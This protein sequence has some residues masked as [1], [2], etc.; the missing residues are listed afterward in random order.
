MTL[1]QLASYDHP[2]YGTGYGEET[3]ENFE[4]FFEQNKSYDV[5]LNLCYR[6]DLRKNDDGT[7]NLEL[8]TILQRKGKVVS[9]YVDKFEQKDVPLLQ[10]YLKPHQDKL[11]MIWSPFVF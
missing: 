5:D 2:Y 6:W 7:Y 8:F 3:Y 10:E 9:H 1:E 11:K 4:D